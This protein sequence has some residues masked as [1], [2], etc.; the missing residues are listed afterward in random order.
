MS[1][2]ELVGLTLL[3]IEQVGDDLHI[4]TKEKG[5]GVITAEGDCCAHAFVESI[6][7]SA[8]L[9]AVITSWEHRDSERESDIDEWG[10]C[11]DYD[12]YLI[13]TSTGFIDIELRT[14]HNGY[15]CGWL[16]DVKWKN[17]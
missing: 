10:E 15:Y 13:K 8:T 9:P 2:D 11:L 16:N 7:N 3:E 17:V 1:N 12:F 5:L 6:N 14:A 4:L